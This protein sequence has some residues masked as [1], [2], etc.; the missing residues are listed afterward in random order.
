MTATEVSLGWDESSVPLHTHACYYYS[1]E[2]TLRR[3][4]EFVRAGLDVPEDLCV[5]FSDSSRFAQLKGWLQ[6]SYSGTVKGLEAS[7]KLAMIG[8]APTTEALVAQIGGRLDEGIRA[9]YKLIRFLGFIAWGEPG[10]PDDRTLLEFESTVNAVVMAYPAVIICTYG[11]PT[12]G[13]NRLVYGGLQTHPIV[14]LGGQ[15]VRDNP[16][17]VPPARVE[18]S[19]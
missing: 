10:W 14:W 3:S 13:G 4:L 6:D 7:G 2:Q 11:V 8:G 15:E 1:D 18:T 17:F 19:K 12:L 16:F 5:I 9:G